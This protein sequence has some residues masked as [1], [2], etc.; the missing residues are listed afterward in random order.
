ML[1]QITPLILTFN[2]EA[3]IARTLERLRWAQ[4]VVIVDSGS[5]DATLALIAQFPNA[6]V[7]A[8]KFDS[9]AQQWNF[10]LHDCNIKT[11]WVL[12][13]DA[14]YVLTEDFT[15]ALRELAPAED[16]GGYKANFRY[17]IHGKQL[18]G[19]LYPAVTVLYRR[20]GAQYVQDGH[21]QRISH[22]H[23]TAMLS[24]YILHDDR[25]VLDRWIAAQVRYA[26]L[27][28]EHLLRTPFSAL[29]WPDRL[30][31]FYVVMPVLALF[32][33]LFL[34]G[35]ILDGRGGLVYAMQRAIAEAVL[36]LVMLENKLGIS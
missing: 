13:L 6:R 17:C 21:T 16:T 8:R 33:C 30:R 5:T 3:N 9:H 20:D 7:H 32:Y 26:R 34:K 4:D 36:S 23:K 29:S 1:S 22:L 35:G 12:A 2:E 25:K 19:S 27:E 14:D 15:T 18:R 10:G 28:L 11:E 24:G 31:R